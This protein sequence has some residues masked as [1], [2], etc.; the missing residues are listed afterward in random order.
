VVDELGFSYDPDQARSILANAGYV[1][2]DGDGF[3][4]M[5]DGSPIALKIIVPFGW[6]DWMESIR[7][8]ANGAQAVGINL[9]P[10]FP[11]Y[12]AYLDAKLNGT[13][14]M[15]LN[16]A[17]V[18]TIQDGNYGR[19]DNQEAFDLVDQL[20]QVPVEDID[21]MREV[22]SDLQRIYFTDMP[23]IPLWYNPLWAQY[24]NAVW[25]NWPSAEEGANH[26]LPASWR[27]YWN[28]SAIQM[29][30]DLEPTPPEE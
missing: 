5:P 22:M 4:E 13:F 16:N 7:V 10:D 20:D 30:C 26:Y 28:L 11:D 17:D 18:A 2:V 24:S 3:V 21:G 27:G 19:Y 1:D 29:L 8:V 15:M 6:T 25:S 14:E 9:E 23:L 12:P